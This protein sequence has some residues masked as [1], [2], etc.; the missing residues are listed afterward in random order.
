[1][2]VSHEP[3]RRLGGWAVRRTVN[4]AIG[5]VMRRPFALIASTWSVAVS[6]RVMSC[7]ARAR[8]APSVPP[9]APAPHTRLRTCPPGAIQERA[10]LFNRDLP[11]REDFSVVALVAAT[12]VA[13]AQMF[14]ERDW[15]HHADL[16]DGSHGPAAVGERH[17]GQAGPG[18]VLHPGAVRRIGIDRLHFGPRFGGVPPI[19]EEDFAARVVGGPFGGE[20]LHGAVPTEIGRA[21]CRERG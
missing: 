4:S 17:A 2:I 11:Q 21:S 12:E 1:M 8:N 15:I 9:I 13:V 18:E 6:T 3:V 5:P 7:P 10:R 16:F 14:L 20:L 19:M